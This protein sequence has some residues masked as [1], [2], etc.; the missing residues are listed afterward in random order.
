MIRTFYIALILLLFLT[1]NSLAGF[2]SSSYSRESGSIVA[3]VQIKDEGIFNMIISANFLRMPQD[4]KIYK[5]DEYEQL[6]DRLQVEWRGIALQK[7]LES[8]ELKIED[9]IHLKNSIHTEI[10]SLT[11]QLKKKL[12]PGQNVEVVFSL[13]DFFLL[14]PI[15]K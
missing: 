1:S 4:K 13:S 14:E 9:L 15:D 3:A 6:M 10:V 7:V 2:Y 11:K 5:S 12:V 8:K